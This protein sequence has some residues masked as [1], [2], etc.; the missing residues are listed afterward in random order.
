MVVMPIYTF[1][2]LKCGR[3]EDIDRPMEARN[4]SFYCSC[5]GETRRVYH[6]TGVIYRG[7][8]FTTVDKRF[9]PTEDDYD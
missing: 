5:G 8:G 9:D 7:I 2:C 4:L 1:R 6:P 3:E